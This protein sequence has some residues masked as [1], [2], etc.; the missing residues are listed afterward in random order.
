MVNE[1]KQFALVDVMNTDGGPEGVFA[2]ITAN[3]EEEA[4]EIALGSG[5]VNKEEAESGYFR[6]HELEVPVRVRFVE[7]TQ[8]DGHY[9]VSGYIEG[10][11][12]KRS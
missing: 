10:E 8:Y 9:Y 6:V 2:I 3:S 11:L 5:T 4:I 12:F 7:K 1:I